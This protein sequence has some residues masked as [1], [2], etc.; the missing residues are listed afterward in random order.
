MAKLYLVRH[1]QAAA[2]F[3]EHKDP[4]LSDLGKTQAAEAAERLAGRGPI[5]IYSSPLK[6]AYETALPLAAKWNA[7]PQIMEAV[8]EIPTPTKDL[9]RRTEW[10][11][12]IMAGTWAEIGDPAVLH[13]RHRVI[14]TLERLD[15]DAVIFSHFIAINVA[16]AHAEGSDSLVVFAP[17]NASITELEIKDGRLHLIKRGAE[18]QTKV[19]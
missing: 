9:T 5:E 8:S 10:L 15:A 12:R 11:R 16:V 13:W 1:G 19:N 3:G 17:N 4:G 7:I 2:S 18:A 14:D 6:R